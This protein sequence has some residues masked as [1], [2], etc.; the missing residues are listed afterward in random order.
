MDQQPV[1]HHVRDGGDTNQGRILLVHCLQF[2]SQTKPRRCDRLRNRT[3]GKGNQPRSWS[4]HWNPPYKL[5][6][7]QNPQTKTH[8]S[9]CQEVCRQDF[10]EFWQWLLLLLK[11]SSCGSKNSIFRY[12]HH[13]RPSGWDPLQWFAED[14][15]HCTSCFI[16]GKVRRVFKEKWLSGKQGRAGPW[17]CWSQELS[18]CSFQSTSP[19]AWHDHSNVKWDRGVHGN[20][21]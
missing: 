9:Y 13:C 19:G 11:K 15:E 12:T 2:H 16:G 18:M 4:S 3:P 1:F 17:S 14:N 8:Y 10:H 5:L 21:G 6:W 20:W 7:P